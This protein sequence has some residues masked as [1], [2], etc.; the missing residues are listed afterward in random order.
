MDEC[1]EFTARGMLINALHCA[2]NDIQETTAR[3]VAKKME[4]EDNLPTGRCPKCGLPIHEIMSAKAVKHFFGCFAGQG[5]AGQGR[6]AAPTASCSGTTTPLRKPARLRC[7][8]SGQTDGSWRCDVASLS[9]RGGALRFRKCHGN[10]TRTNC[11]LWRALQLLEY[12]RGLPRTGVLL[13]LSG[14]LFQRGCGS[15]TGALLY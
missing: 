8:R 15:A 11:I 14:I 9:R 5:R 13:S 2:V 10:I 12:L 4:S 1:C 6:A 3:T 7:R